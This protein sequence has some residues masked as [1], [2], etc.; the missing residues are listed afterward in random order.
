M[1]R[2]G[3]GIVVA[4]KRSITQLERIKDELPAAERRLFERYYRVDT[5]TGRLRVPEGMRPWIEKNFGILEAVTEQ[6]IVKETNRLTLEGVLFNGLRASRPM[7]VADGDSVEETVVKSS[8][9]PF[10]RP[11]S[12]TTED[13]FGRIRGEYCIT[14]SNVAK[15][16]GY[17]GIVIFDEHHPLKFDAERIADY[18]K[19]AWEWGEKAHQEDPE[20]RYFFLMWNCL[21]KSGASIVHGHAQMTLSR[22]MHYAKAEALRRVWERY[23]REYEG[24]CYFW[25][26]Y[27]VHQSLGLAWEQEGVKGMA[28]LTPVKEKEVLLVAAELGEPL[29]RQVYRVLDGYRRM[30]VR[31]FNLAVYVPPIAEVEED[32]EGFPV[33]VRL[34]DRGDLESRTADVGAMEL[35]AASVIS[36]DPFRVVEFL[37]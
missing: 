5:V 1:I 18:F 28:H 22:G 33:V 3:G 9:D 25:D 27:A 16:D 31:S 36:S 23:K 19:T 15:Y 30:G 13:T 2:T 12:D 34:V 35:Y 8:G 21:W 20:S 29:Y 37:K 7:A 4:M 14:A 17:H 32:W 11:E 26:L 24:A 6:R 10:C